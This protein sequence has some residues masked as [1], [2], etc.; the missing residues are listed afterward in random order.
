M[1]NIL[2]LLLI[3]AILCPLTATADEGMWLLSQLKELDLQKQGLEL[4]TSDIYH[5][6]KPSITDAIVWLGGCSASF[7]SEDGLILTNHHC[8]FRALQRASQ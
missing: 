2:T 6:K 3:A 1:K 5:P 7:V 4:K 8:A